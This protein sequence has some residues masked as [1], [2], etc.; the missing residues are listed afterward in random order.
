LGIVMLAQAQPATGQQHPFGI[1]LSNNVV[2]LPVTGMPA[3]TFTQF[4]PGLDLFSGVQLNSHT[5]H[6]LWVHG[7]LG[8]YYHRFFQTGIRLHGS[9]DYRHAF[10]SGFSLDAGIM[11]GYMQSFTWYDVFT[12]NDDG[13]YE[14]I[15]TF[16][17]RPQFLGGFRI[18]ASHPLM[19][20]RLNG[21]AIHLDLRTYLQAP[22]AGA[23]IP[24]IPTNTLMIGI[25]KKVTCK[26]E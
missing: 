12:M 11:A 26:S 7:N 5:K 23:Y 3:T 2:A 25:S 24:I 22:F 15:S 4:H 18:G 17:G 1:A 14:K 20:E 16:R 6:Q 19:P 21:F 9:L 10:L 13:V 8:A